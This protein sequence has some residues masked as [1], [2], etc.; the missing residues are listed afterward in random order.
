ME[1]LGPRLQGA[2]LEDSRLHVELGV[3]PGSPNFLRPLS[4]VPHGYSFG[5]IALAATIPDW[6]LSAWR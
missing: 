5:G 6:D 2:D 4:D 1:T 3:E